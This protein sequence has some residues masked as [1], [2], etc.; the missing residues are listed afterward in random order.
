[1]SESVAD[2]RARI[3]AGI[4][5]HIAETPAP[6]SYTEVFRR[7]LATT[8]LAEEESGEDI[9][10]AMSCLIFAGTILCSGFDRDKAE[11]TY[12]ADTDMVLCPWLLRFVWSERLADADGGGA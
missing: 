2:L 6:V 8:G 10:D 9:R 1:M 12:S 3:I 4:L 11:V 7:T 5:Q